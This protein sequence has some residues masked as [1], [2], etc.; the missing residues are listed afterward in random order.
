M[1]KNSQNTRIQQLTFWT[2]D[3]YSN[4]HSYQNTKDFLNQHHLFH[5]LSIFIGRP[6]DTFWKATEKV[7]DGLEKK[8]GI[9]KIAHQKNMPHRQYFKIL[10]YLCNQ[11]YTTRLNNNN[12][13]PIIYVEKTI[14][15]DESFRTILCLLR[16]RND[17]PST[18]YASRQT[19]TRGICLQRH[20]DSRI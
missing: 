18:C 15:Y 20:A 6:S 2:I 9:W 14:S 13:K 4:S 16:T 7:L 12:L 5:S 17:K 19:A 3:S 10:L 11:K 8:V 1:K